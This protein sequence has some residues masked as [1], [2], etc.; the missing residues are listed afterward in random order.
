MIDK[1]DFSRC[2]CENAGW[3]N[4][5]KKEMPSNPPSWQWCQ[6][7]TPSQREEYYK[8]NVIQSSMKNIKDMI[9]KV[10]IVQFYDKLPEIQSDYA[11]CVIPAN[12]DAV[13]LLDV[14]RDSIIRYAKK[15]G[16][17]Y[18]ELS[19]NQHPD[20][21]MANKYR[22]HQVS[23]RYKK[24]LYVDC[25]VAIKDETPN[26]FQITPDDKISACSDF[27]RFKKWSDTEWIRNEQELIVHKV[28]NSN[29]KNIKNGKFEATEMLN[30]GFLVIP[31]SLADYYKQPSKP[32]PRQW[33]FDQNYLTLTLPDDK[34]NLLSLKFNNTTVAST[35]SKDTIICSEFWE[36][37]D[38]CY[39]VHANGI[40]NNEIRKDI[41][42]SFFDGSIRTKQSTVKTNTQNNT[43]KP[44]TIQ[45]NPSWV[46]VVEPEEPVIVPQ[47]D[48]A[49]IMLAAGPSGREMAQ[50]TGPAAKRYAEKIGSD[51]VMIGGEVANLK[52]PCG[53]KFRIR[54]YAKYYRRS[55]YIDADVF[56][57]KNAPNLFEI[58]PEGTVGMTDTFFTHIKPYKKHPNPNFDVIRDWVIPEVSEIMLSQGEEPTPSQIKK[59]WNSGLIVLDPD[60]A[61][62]YFEP[63]KRPCPPFWCSEEHWCRRNI[64]VHELIISEI[65]T[66][67]HWG[68]WWDQ[69]F[70]EFEQSNASFL[71][72]AGMGHNVPWW[73]A[74]D[75]EWR[76]RILRILGT[77]D[78]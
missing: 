49:V 46:L 3:C 69:D 34:L 41:L 15:C 10:D 37:L 51:F 66:S 16:A 78:K 11:V 5:F 63:M 59:H 8:K 9:S 74:T 48:T 76:V 13:S 17:D 53:D 73:A 36:E 4:L 72:L 26:I 38:E 31:Q 30:G 7:I 52:F 71:H 61:Q 25:D 67:I 57:R 1:I 29:H 50:F 2:R 12:Q 42:I 68:W 21:V 32:Y 40:K 27:T 18:I 56:I 77:L 35:K 62:K 28:L 54:H 24:T 6:S 45:H 58:V 65:P 19:G 55:I 43:D 33:C 60:L 70:K 23:S 64:D 20:W 14:T 22:A 47:K 75:M 39:I 44:K